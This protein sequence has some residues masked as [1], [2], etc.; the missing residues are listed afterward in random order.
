MKI[1][2]FIIFFNFN[3]DDST[4]VT[5]NLEHV[6]RAIQIRFDFGLKIDIERTKL[7][8]IKRNKVFDEDLVIN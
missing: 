4:I 8:A 1:Y 7:I 5:K 6:Q 3:T 2:K